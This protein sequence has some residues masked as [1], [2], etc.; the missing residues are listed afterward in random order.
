MFA[1][2]AYGLPSAVLPGGFDTMIIS[3]SRRTDI[4][5]FYARWFMNRIE[6]GYCTVPNPFNR[7]Q[8]SYVSLDPQNVDVIVFWTR[9]PRPVMPHLKEL[10]QRGYRY[11]FQY[12]LMN[13]PRV[14][15]PKCPALETSLKTFRELSDLIGPRKIVWRYDP[16]VM[17]SITEPDFHEE[18]YH[19]IAQE[20]KGYTYRSVVSL[21]NVYRKARKRLSKLE[22][23]GIELLDW[24]H[25]AYGDMIPALVQIAHDNDMEIV[26]CA[27]EVDLKLY[28][29]R[30]GKCVDDEYVLKVFGLALNVKKDPGQ[31]KE[32]G[33]VISKDIGMYDSCLYECCYCYATA[34]FGCARTNYRNHD[35]NSPSLIGWYDVKPKPE[36]PVQLKLRG[37]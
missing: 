25:A 17:S 2:T 29:I 9:N 14:M 28:G 22:G 8:I 1:T 24:N 33:C 5:A 36:L 7:N 3:A 30:P 31:R 23:K 16:I 27:E 12:T 20:L 11:Y 18:T 32:C 34:S 15:D 4:P 19:F 6:A 35:P 10:D 26:S 13:N 21:A 37:P